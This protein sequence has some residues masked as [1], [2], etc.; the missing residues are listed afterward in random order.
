MTDESTE[1]QEVAPDTEGAPEASTNTEGEATGT[2]PKDVQA[3]FTKKSQALADERRQFQTQQQE[4]QQQQQRQQQQMQHYAQQLQQQQGTQGQ[5]N[6]AQLL[7]Q[8]RGMSYLDGPT[9]AQLMERIINEGINPLNT[10]IQQRDQALTR[11]Y[12]EYKSLKEGL[13]KQT[14]KSAEAELSS[15]FHKV[16][17]EQGLPDEPSVNQY[18]QDVYY[19]HEGN[20]L[21][22]EYP[23]LVRERIDTMR[24]AFR[25][26]DRKA[27]AAAKEKSPFPGKGG[28]V[29]F[30]DGKTGGYK[31]PQDRADELWPMINPGTPTE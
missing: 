19:S 31:S 15:R 12:Q 25:D 8:L 23:G 22:T 13:G 11:M 14:S 24:K 30:T 5:Q 2:W 10:A 18:L 9:A 26:M 27:A 29:S 16:R 4:W 3:E 21:D 6:Q 20:D 1:V 7:D 28:E 17:D